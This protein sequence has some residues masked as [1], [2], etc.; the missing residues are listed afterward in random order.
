MQVADAG[1]EVIAPEKSIKPRS[2]RKNHL[3]ILLLHS[4]NDKQVSVS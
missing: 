3:N 1:G 2:K 4:K